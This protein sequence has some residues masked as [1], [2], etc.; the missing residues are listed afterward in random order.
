[1]LLTFGCKIENCRTGK[2]TAIYERNIFETEGG[3]P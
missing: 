1:M 3:C 2:V